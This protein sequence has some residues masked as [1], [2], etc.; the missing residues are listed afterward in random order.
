MASSGPASRYA[1]SGVKENATE[2]FEETRA[3]IRALL[4]D[5]NISQEQRAQLQQ[6]LQ[7]LTADYSDNG[8]THVSGSGVSAKTR[9]NRA[10]RVYRDFIESTHQLQSELYGAYAQLLGDAPASGA[11]TAAA[12]STDDMVDDPKA[13]F[14]LWEQDP[15]E[16]AELYRDLDSEDRQQVTMRLQGLLQSEHQLFTL[17]SNLQQTQH[18]TNRALMA[19]IRV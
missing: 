15:A 11:G 4:A 13:M 5:P 2:L 9:N 19:N 3:D 18:D 1:A 6:Q 14:A 12:S 10:N 17:M 7:E 16:F 8:E